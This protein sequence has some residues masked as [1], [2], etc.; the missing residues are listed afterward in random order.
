MQIHKS[1]L[2]EGH[3][4]RGK[5]VRPLNALRHNFILRLL[6]Q[7]SKTDEAVTLSERN[8]TRQKWFETKQV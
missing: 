4:I 8:L 3:L 5:L 7:T 1:K 2:D 6:V